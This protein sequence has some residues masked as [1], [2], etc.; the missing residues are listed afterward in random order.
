MQTSTDYKERHDNVVESVHMKI[1]S[2]HCLLDKKNDEPYFCHIPYPVMENVEYC[3][4][5]NKPI[6]IDLMVRR[7]SLDIIKAEEKRR[8]NAM[9]IDIAVPSDSNLKR[10]NKVQRLEFLAD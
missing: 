2:K 10:K 6:L 5:R 8:K 3:V 9:I 4:C 1:G 7:R